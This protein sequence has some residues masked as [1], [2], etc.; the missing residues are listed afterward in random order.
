MSFQLEKVI[1]KLSLFGKFLEAV[2]LPKLTSVGG[3]L[4]VGGSWSGWQ[5]EKLTDLSF[6]AALTSVEKLEIKFC[7][8]LTD[9]SGLKKKR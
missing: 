6:L 2:Y 3:N 4:E 1:G 8:F 7:K 5:N 9:F